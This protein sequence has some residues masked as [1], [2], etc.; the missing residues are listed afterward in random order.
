[1]T[2]HQ[3]ALKCLRE[4]NE[5]ETEGLCILLVLDP[6]E[7]PE[8]VSNTTDFWKIIKEL[9]KRANLLEEQVLLSTVRPNLEVH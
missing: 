2:A 5:R 6:G 1:M 8:F 9:R 4:Y 3:F 7:L